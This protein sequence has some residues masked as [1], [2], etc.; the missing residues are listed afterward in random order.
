MP[1]PYWLASS[2]FLA[3]LLLLPAC[4]KTK[5]PSPEFQQAH[6][7]FTQLYAQKLNAAFLD[8]QMAEV[9]ALL[10]AVRPDS[11]DA[12]AAA[13]LK[14]RIAEG[15]AHQAQVAADLSK[16]NAPLPVGETPPTPAPTVAPPPEVDAGVD[17]GT[18][19]QPTVGQ[20]A[21]EFNRRFATCFTAGPTLQMEG[22]GAVESHVLKD[23]EMCRRQ[24]PG[25][26]GRAVII[27]QS[28]VHA[29][30]ELNKIERRQPDG[31]KVEAADSGR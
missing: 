7:L 18:G 4:P 8:P 13:E 31:G 11:L 27:S 1:R 3:L 26:V 20:S 15:K 24:H 30:A 21:A 19:D 10:G 23:I 25:F 12:A 14:A 6:Q 16:V 28:K 2:L 17:A 9:E 22:Q 5:Q 29:L